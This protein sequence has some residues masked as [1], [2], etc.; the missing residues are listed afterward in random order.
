LSKEGLGPILSLTLA[1]VVLTIGAGVTRYLPVL[2]LAGVAW[3]A[4]LF[5]LYFFRDPERMIPAGENLI[6]SP[7]DGK[8]V[9]VV[10]VVE[11]DYLKTEATKVSIFLSPFNVHINRIPM[12]GGV[13]YFRYVRGKYHR[14]FTDAA[15]SENEQ[16]VIGI[17]GQRCSLLFK[18]IAGVIARRIVCRLREGH[19]VVKGERFGMIKFGSRV[20]VFLPK[21]VEVKVK[22]NQKVKAGEA[23]IGVIRNVA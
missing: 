12:D 10:E 2:I 1:A 21:S 14:A 15:S 13:D 3:V 18:Q 11:P 7:A 22:I 6:L 8:I 5:A 4:V 19:R 9:V 23:V 20:D 16:T 17:R